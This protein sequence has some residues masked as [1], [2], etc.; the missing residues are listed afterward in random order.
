MSLNIL[1][2]QIQEILA[3]KI[4]FSWAKQ[5]NSTMLYC[6]FFFMD[7]IFMFEG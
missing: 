1:K 6:S 2:I 3:T 4:Y 7:F 5:T